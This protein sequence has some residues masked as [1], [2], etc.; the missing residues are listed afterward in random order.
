MKKNYKNKILDMSVAAAMLLGSSAYAGKIIGANPPSA[1][2]EPNLSQQFG[3]GGW[4]FGNVDVRIVNINDFSTPLPG[5]IF[6]TTDGTYTSMDYNQSFESV[7]K[8]IGS[9]EERGLLHGKNWPVGEPAGI[10]II[11]DDS[12]TKNGKPENCI[13]TTSYLD[14]EDNP[15]KV[16][17]YLDGDTPTPTVCSSSFQTHKRFKINMLPTTVANLDAERYGQPVDLVFKLVGG[18]TTTERYQV[19]QKINNYTGLRLDGYKIEVLDGSGNPN[20]ALTL[21]IG[22]LENPKSTGA[23]NIWDVEDMANFS[24]GLWGPQ[25]YEVPVPHFPTDGFF[26]LKRAG[27]VVDPSGHNTNTLVGGPT[28]LGSNYVDLF[29]IWL[30]STWAPKGIFFDDDNDPT[31]DAELIAFWGTVPNAPRGTLPEWHKGQA[32]GWA[33]PTAE[34]LLTWHTDPLY[35]MDVVEDTLNL[36]LNYI[37]N[38]GDNTQ[39]ATSTFIVRIT[40]RVAEDQTPPN[41][42]DDNLNYIM[43]PTDYN[44]TDP[45]LIISPAPLFNLNAD[46]SVGVADPALNNDDKTIED[47]V[48]VITTTSGDEENLTL[49]ET[50]VNSSIFVGTIGSDTNA[51]E[52]Q[53]E[54]INVVNGTV[55]TATYGA[56]TAKTTATDITTT[57]GTTTTLDPSS[58]GGGCTYNP[59]SKK[60]D[61]GFLLMMALGLLY[62][63]RRRF[64]K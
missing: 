25:T 47:T 32:T 26:D 30:H 16:Y 4:D 31:T 15:F 14:T 41:Y 57:D 5:T 53:N 2:L 27:F 44:G 38:V 43:P 13:M 60:F 55:V 45:L 24:H 18:D 64:I 50:D 34:E 28:T 51:V 56:L 48:I 23:I 17:G 20:N 9:A 63:I 39:I 59:D 49:T 29:G 37:V 12:D 33:V 6:D 61:M 19:F 11:N 36:G 7:I 46:L 1:P 62:P 58:G 3:F 40:P 54:T 35:S 10:K 22:L 21:S 42:V 8:E 52:V